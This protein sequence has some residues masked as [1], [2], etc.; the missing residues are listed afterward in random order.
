MGRFDGNM[1][2]LVE[3]YSL[4]L[5]LETGLLPNV[6]IY[7]DRRW[8]ELFYSYVEEPVIMSHFCNSFL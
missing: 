3:F 5:P 6:L 2:V 1:A 8:M 7:F 4:H